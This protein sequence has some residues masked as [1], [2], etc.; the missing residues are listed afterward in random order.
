M[1]RISALFLTLCCSS[2]L[3]A[4]V[5]IAPF[6]GYGFGASEFNVYSTQNNDYGTVKV[7]ESE[8]YGLML[9]INTDDL[10]NVYLLYS[11]QT[12]D[13]RS[14]NLFSPA[15]LTPIEVDYLH[16]GGSLYFPVKRANPYITTSFG[17]TQ[18][19]PGDAYATE[20]RFSMALGTGIEF[21]PTSRLAIFAEVKAYA[22][23]INANNELFCNGHS[24]VWN[25]QSDIM[26]Q[27]QANIGASLKF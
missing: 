23:F 21:N 12:T 7:S 9:G 8:H 10:G 5:Y 13:L 11:H 25:V 15:L 20:T 1:N 18:M 26:W 14:N 17:L 19:R 27:G 2:P 16:V 24:C 3:M 6:S 4:N 22:T